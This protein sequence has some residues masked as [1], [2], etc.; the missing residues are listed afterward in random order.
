MATMDN[1]TLDREAR[2]AKLL[3]IENEYR[4]IYEILQRMKQESNDVFDD[5][6]TRI[7]N[8][9]IPV[10]W[11][12]YFGENVKSHIKLVIDIYRILF[13]KW[14]RENSITDCVP[15]NK[16]LFVSERLRNLSSVLKDR[17]GTINGLIKKGYDITLL[18][19]KEMDEVGKQFLSDKKVM[20]FTG[21]IDDDAK[22]IKD[23]QF[24][25]IVYCDLHMSEESSCLS[26]L[27]LSNITFNT[28]GHSETSGTCDYFV[29]SMLYELENGEN[30]YL[31]C[32][33]LH[34]GLAITYNP[35]YQFNN[36]P[37]R[38]RAYFGIPENCNLYVCSS[39]L[40]KIGKEYIEAIKIITRDDLH[41]KVVICRV[42]NDQDERFF[43]WLDDQGL[44]EHIIFLPRQ[45]TFDIGALYGCAD[46]VLESYPFGNLNTSMECFCL[47]TPVVAWETNKMNSRFTS[48]YLR[49]M[50]LDDLI[51]PPHGSPAE[52]AQRAIAVAKEKRQREMY[53]KQHAHL[54]WNSEKAVDEW[55]KSLNL[56]FVVMRN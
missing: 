23:G 25:T 36:L 48:A 4:Q 28:F 10:F 18:T 38:S 16:I 7:L 2:Q 24:S 30:N 51:I 13:D 19:K 33:N 56:N 14:I 20:F 9:A 15:G 50:G 12:S 45:G 47:G 32:R 29:G 21:N 35:P 26:L 44:T 55:E 5:I 17:M 27:K 11:L 22:L 6:D 53:I 39:S 34:S 46:V 49:I 1:W 54:L 40:F 3:K 43:K 37:K 52:F 8:K 41:S 31:E 42:G